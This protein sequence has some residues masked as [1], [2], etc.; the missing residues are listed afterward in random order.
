MQRSN[1]AISQV[2]GAL[3][4]AQAELESPEKAL[5]ATIASPSPREESRRTFRYALLAS[6]LEIVR[7]CLTEHE[8]ATVRPRR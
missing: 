5:T 3:A 7:K 4:R 8:I 1:E 6:G 2:A